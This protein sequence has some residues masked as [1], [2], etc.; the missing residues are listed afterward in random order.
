MERRLVGNCKSKA[1]SDICENKVS[2]FLYRNSATNELMEYGDP[3]PAHIPSNNDLR[4]TKCRNLKLK[5]LSE[6]PIAINHIMY[7]PKFQ[8]SVKR[9]RK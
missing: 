3:E 6:D 2:L 7:N 9:V 1:Y 4:I 5:K 8:N